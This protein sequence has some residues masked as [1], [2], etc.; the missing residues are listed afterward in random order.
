MLRHQPLTAANP[1]ETE[2]NGTTEKERKNLLSYGTSRLCTAQFLK[3]KQEEQQRD[4][5]TITNSEAKQNPK[6]AVQ[7]EELR[8]KQ[9]VVEHQ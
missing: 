1:I 3:W 6:Q 4:G 2:T 5:R 7:E 8:R 9:G